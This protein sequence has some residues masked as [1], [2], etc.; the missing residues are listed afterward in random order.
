MRV[1]DFIFASKISEVASLMREIGDSAFLMAGGT[2]TYFI[3]SKTSKV[4][5]DITKLP[6]KGISRV[7]D[8]YKI[9][10]LTTINELQKFKD[11]GWVLDRVARIIA[12]QQIRNISTI[13]GNLARVFYWS[14]MPVALLAL[15]GS[16]KFSGIAS[17]HVKIAEVFSKPHSH[18]DVFTASILDYIEIPAATK[19]MGFSYQKETRTYGAFSSAT[20]AAFIKIEEGVISEAR[21]AIGSVLPFPVRLT[22]V[23]DFLVGKRPECKLLGEIHFDKLAKMKLM[24][25]EFMTDEFCIHLIKIKAKD[26][27]CEAM[28]EAMGGCK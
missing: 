1:K 5:I 27:I 3:A 4:A 2:S 16:L 7:N 6:L 8:N 10:A 24:P 17:R 15:G 28:K 12:N 20:A 19:G 21:V 13:G 26:A 23:E 14:D 9:G 18:K 11:E 22:D 25:R